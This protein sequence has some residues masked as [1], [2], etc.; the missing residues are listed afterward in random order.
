MYTQFVIEY[1][2][3]IKY[4]SLEVKHLFGAYCIGSLMLTAFK[5]KKQHKI[6]YVFGKIKYTHAQK[7]AK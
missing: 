1:I 3:Y 2:A 6:W 5:N 4:L 7:E